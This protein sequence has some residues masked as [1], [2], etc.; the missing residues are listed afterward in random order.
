MPLSLVSDN[1]N[2]QDSSIGAFVRSIVHITETSSHTHEHTVHRLLCDL[3][4]L[5]HTR[6]LSTGEYYTIVGKGADVADFFHYDVE[7]LSTEANSWY[8]ASLIHQIGQ[9]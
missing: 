6:R 7:H 9:G 3:N 5:H 1:M 2:V 4:E 8:R